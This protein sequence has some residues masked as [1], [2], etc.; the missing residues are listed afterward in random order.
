MKI[1]NIA[2]LLTKEILH[3]KLML[4]YFIEVFFVRVGSFANNQEKQVILKCRQ[5]LEREEPITSI[6]VKE[7]N[8]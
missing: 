3:I 1:F 2:N 6:I 8:N 7:T 4:V 5:F